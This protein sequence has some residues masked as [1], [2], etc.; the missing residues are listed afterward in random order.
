MSMVLSFQLVGSVFNVKSVYALENIE[1]LGVAAQ[2]YIE[3]TPLKKVYKVVG[4]DGIEHI[5]EYI[6]NS[7]KVYTNGREVVYSIKNGTPVHIEDITTKNNNSS[8]YATTNAWTPV[9]VVEDYYID[10]APFIDAT[11]TVASYVLDF[12]STF[13]AIAGA[14]LVTKLAEASVK[15][16]F[17]ELLDEAYDELV[18]HILSNASD[19]FDVTFYYD[20]QR[21]SGLVDLM[22]SGV[23]VYAYRYANYAGRIWVRGRQFS[24]NTAEHGSWWSSSKPYSIDLPMEEI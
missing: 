24:C 18:D 22:G 21:T 20:L 19:Y 9:T 13:S 4:E 3:E 17:E 6:K 15:D 16:L 10:F 8:L 23:M 14:T 7:G 12:Y 1:I 11:A 5:S 2:M